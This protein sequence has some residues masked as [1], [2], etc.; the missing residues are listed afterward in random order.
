MNSGER[1]NNKIVVAVDPDSDARTLVEAAAEL[2]SA[3]HAEWEAIHIETPSDIG[4]DQEPAAE[5]LRLAAELGATVAKLSAADVPCGLSAHLDNNPAGH[6]VVGSPRRRGGLFRARSSID[7]LLALQ[8]DVILHVV[9]TARSRPAATLSSDPALL[10]YAYAIGGVALTLIV[11]LL[12]RLAAG[13]Q[14]LSFL[15]LFPVIAAAARL[16]TKPAVAAAVAASL[17]FNF[18]FVEP[19]YSIRPTAI[20]SWIM[21][22]ALVVVAVYT[23]ALTANLRGRALLSERSA[24]ESAS[25]ATFGSEL[26]RAADWESTAQVIC[27]D[28]S[29]IFDVQTVLVREIAGSLEV[30]A[31]APEKIALDPLERTALEWAW[32]NG[33]P[34]GSG[35]AAVSAASW[36]FEPLRTSL[37]TL[38]VLGLVRADGR[39]PVPAERKLLLSTMVSQ[40]ALALERLR[41]EDIMKAR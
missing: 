10:G 8:P 1:A 28:V 33:E 27:S 31:G 37:A 25:I 2:A 4:R 5:A 35:T 12:L 41:L 21:A 20:Q 23:G 6:L 29:A 14:S 32:Q 19:I 36:R 3:L 18:F 34:S 7:E 38:A 15:F 13:V 30:V 11:A 22:V 17:A 24:Q 16:G 26:A 39:D 40:S 9:P